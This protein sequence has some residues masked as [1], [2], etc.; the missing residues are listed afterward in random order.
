VLR[1]YLPGVAL[2]LTV[3]L[4]A[5]DWPLGWTLWV[6]H[7]FVAALAAG[8]VLLLLTGSVVDAILRRRE[9]RRWRDLGR[10]AAYALD[11]V[12]WLSRIAL[13]QLLGARGDIQLTLEIELHVGPARDRALELLGQVPESDELDIMTEYD[14]D[15]ATLLQDARLPTLLRDPAWCDRAMFALLTLARVQETTIARWV[16]AFGVLGDSEGFR[17]IGESIAIADRAEAIGQYLLVLRRGEVSA[18][19]DEAAIGATSHAV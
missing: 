18:E 7:P 15:R 14:L 13:F 17:R 1:Q 8:L 16:G 19:L 6:D 12:F 3:A 2:A 5:T 11:Q 9:A 4:V 10:G